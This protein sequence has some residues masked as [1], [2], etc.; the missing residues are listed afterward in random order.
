MRSVV[1]KAAAV[2]A[3]LLLGG[4]GWCECGGGPYISSPSGDALDTARSFTIRY[5][6]WRN[7]PDEIKALI[8]AQCGPDYPLAQMLT[9]P[10][11]GTVLHPQQA[12]VTC[13]KDRPSP[14]T[15]GDAKII[16][17]R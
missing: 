17:L 5:S 2:A 6:D 4:C 8:A 10:Y 13:I 1:S 15:L 7:G 12:A 3:L 14:A 9:T 11:Q 16:P